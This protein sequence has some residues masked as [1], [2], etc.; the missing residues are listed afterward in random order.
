MRA[1]AHVPLGV[2]IESV[3]L[4]KGSV[5]PLIAPSEAT[6]L[7]VNFMKLTSLE[8]VPKAVDTATVYICIV[9]VP[10]TTD[11]VKIT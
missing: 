10:R 2:A 5:L 3:E 8:S 4:A 9:L 6:V 11:L 7:K 1:K